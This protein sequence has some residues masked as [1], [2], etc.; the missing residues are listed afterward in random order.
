MGIL[1]V[2]KWDKRIRNHYSEGIKFIY[3]TEQEDFNFQYE[4][5]EYLAKVYV[6]AGFPA[7]YNGW[8]TVQFIE[9]KVGEKV[10][11]KRRIKAFKIANK[12]KLSPIYF[13]EQIIGAQRID[14]T[15]GYL[16]Y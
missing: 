3:Y 1:I 2:L 9:Q 10:P 11:M 5:N 7:Y 6:D 8:A 13:V 15:E 16:K 4:Y 14:Y 12:E